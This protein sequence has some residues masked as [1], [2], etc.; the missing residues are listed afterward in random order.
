LPLRG[1][2]T[3]HPAGAPRRRR[4]PQ[5]NNEPRPEPPLRGDQATSSTGGEKPPLRGDQTIYPTGVSRRFSQ[6][7][8]FIAMRLFRTKKNTSFLG[9][10][11]FFSLQCLNSSFSCFFLKKKCE[12]YAPRY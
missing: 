1:D 9:Q 7:A 11:Q 4:Q 6:N 8:D 12:K 2:Q 10:K 3:T 5:L